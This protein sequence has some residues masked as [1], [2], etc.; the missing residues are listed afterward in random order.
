MRV[1]DRK[2]LRDLKRLWSQALAIALVTAVG[3][4]GFVM[5]LGTIDS[6]E[7]TQAVYYE[8]YRFADVFASVRRAPESLA[9]KLA[10]ISG[11][12]QVSTRITH[13]VVLDIEGMSE[14]V[15]GLLS[16]LPEAGGLNQIH[17]RRGRVALPGSTQEVVLTEAFA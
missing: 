7:Q 5:S 4:A 16:S 2:I 8:R 6:L 1:L 14:P 11:V 12:K 17:L 13:N 15:N 3:T 10:A 9:D